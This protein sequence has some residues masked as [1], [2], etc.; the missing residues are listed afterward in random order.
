MV[1]ADFDPSNIRPVQRRPVQHPKLNPWISRRVCVDYLVGFEYL[2]GSLLLVY[3][4]DKSKFVNHD[5]N[6][7][8]FHGSATN[9]SSHSPAAQKSI[10][11]CIITDEH[12][13][14]RLIGVQPPL[15]RLMGLAGSKEV[16]CGLA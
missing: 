14:S 11:E 5:A 7:R 10:D 6:R 3:P 1:V 16:K 12:F 13:A 2:T 8:L 9:L 4:L 15:V